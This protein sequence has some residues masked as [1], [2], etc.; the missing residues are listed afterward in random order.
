M[1]INLPQETRS[2]MNFQR[3][4][5]IS[6][7]AILAQFVLVSPVLAQDKPEARGAGES[8]LALRD[9]WR[10]QTSAKV[11]AKGEVISTPKFSTQGWHEATVPTTV[12]AA[13][14]RIRLCLIPSLG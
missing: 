7:I 10:L 6:F 14:V 11:E 3:R 8:K 2:I 12:V 9:A 1:T 4:D 5:V 13:L